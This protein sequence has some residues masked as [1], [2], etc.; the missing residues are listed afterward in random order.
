MQATFMGV[1]FLLI[2]KIAS[3]SSF[4]L[5]FRFPLKNCVKLLLYIEK[6]ALYAPL[7]KTIALPYRCHAQRMLKHDGVS[8]NARQASGGFWF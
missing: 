7:F 3:R 8:K 2:T 5:K 4:R 6:K 1:A